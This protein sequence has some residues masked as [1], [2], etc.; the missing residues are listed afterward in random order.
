LALLL[1]FQL[2]ELQAVPSLS[3]EQVPKSSSAA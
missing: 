3:G 2:H 1:R